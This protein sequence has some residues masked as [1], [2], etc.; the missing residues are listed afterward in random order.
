LLST[1]IITANMFCPSFERCSVAEVLMPYGRG[2]VMARPDCFGYCHIV[3]VRL[4]RLG[5]FVSSGTVTLLAVDGNVVA[6]PNMIGCGAVDQHGA[7]LDVRGQLRRDRQVARRF[8]RKLLR[9]HGRAPR[10]LITDKLGS[11]AAANREIGLSVEH[12]QHKGLNN[13]AENTY[14]SS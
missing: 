4:A 3:D 6:I 9:K 11:Y 13:R 5:S 7:V 14:R 2:W 1:K 12:R 10:V 8:M